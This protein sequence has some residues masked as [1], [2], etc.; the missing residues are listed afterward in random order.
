L[1]VSFILFKVLDKTKVIN[2]TQNHKDRVNLALSTMYVL[3]MLMVTFQTSLTIIFFDTVGL[4]VMQGKIAK[5]Y[6][7]IQLIL[8]L[9]VIL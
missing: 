2:V 6:V 7:F 5:S 9:A 1:F 3:T 8:F 4:A